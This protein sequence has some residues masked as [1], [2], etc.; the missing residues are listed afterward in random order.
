MMT[1]QRG[2]M[3]RPF[4]AGAL[5]LTQKKF[6]SSDTQIPVHKYSIA[7]ISTKVTFGDRLQVRS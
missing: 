3:P 4:V 2:P 5:S 6:G 7:N 1:A